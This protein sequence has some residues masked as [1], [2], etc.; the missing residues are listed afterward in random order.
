MTPLDRVLDVMW[1]VIASAD[2]DQVLEPPRHEELTVLDEPEIARPEKRPLSGVTQP[3]GEGLPGLLR[4]APVAPRHARARDPDLADAI[5]LTAGAGFGIGDD[6]REVGRHT[7]A[8]D[9]P[10]RIGLFVGGVDDLTLLQQRRAHRARDG[11]G[12]GVPAGNQQRRL[13]EPVARVK[14]LAAEAT[15]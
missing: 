2:D 14:D 10:P 1:M 15:A 8:P 13:G 4:A 7:A 6:N 9:H 5:G 12:P 3:S 11:A